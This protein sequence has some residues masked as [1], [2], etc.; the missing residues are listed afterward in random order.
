MLGILGP[1]RS[2]II[3]LITLSTIGKLCPLETLLPSSLFSCSRLSFRGQWTIRHTHR[4]DLGNEF[5]REDKQE[6]QTREAA[7]PDGMV[8]PRRLS[9]LRH[10][11]YRFSFC[12]FVR[13]AAAAAAEDRGIAQS[14]D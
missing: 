8:K 1:Q 3:N 2:I 11:K 12:A 9:M 10:G 13:T 14:Q 7:Y 6:R 4:E 5:V